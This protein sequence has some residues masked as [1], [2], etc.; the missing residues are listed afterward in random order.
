ML[1]VGT[2]YRI[3]LHQKSGT[4]GNA[5]LE[6]F[7]ATGDAAFGA[8]FAGS[9]TQSFTTAADR[10]RFG[11]TTGTLNAVFDDIKLDSASLP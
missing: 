4:S 11:A 10:L 2:I 1:N 3:A 5:V 6:A 8:P 9:S 7:L